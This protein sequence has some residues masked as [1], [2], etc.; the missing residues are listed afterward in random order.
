MNRNPFIRPRIASE[1]PKEILSEKPAPAR[2]YFFDDGRFRLIGTRDYLL[3]KCSCG[4]CQKAPAASVQKH[5]TIYCP[6]GALLILDDKFIDAWQKVR[7]QMTLLHKA[8]GG[9]NV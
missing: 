6:C 1:P 8:Q 3:S 7:I 4:A 5:L 9:A 2:G